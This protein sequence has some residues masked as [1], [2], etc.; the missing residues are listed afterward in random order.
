M[1]PGFT[2]KSS[3]SSMVSGSGFEKEEEDKEI[4]EIPLEEQLIITGG[5]EQAPAIE[6]VE[7]EKAEFEKEGGFD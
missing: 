3:G 2:V 5:F 4:K 1:G 6:K 7:F